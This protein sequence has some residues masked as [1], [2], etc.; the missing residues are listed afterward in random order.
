MKSLWLQLKLQAQVQVANLSRKHEKMKYLMS[1]CRYV[2]I[3]LW[4][5]AIFLG[6]GCALGGV[7]VPW[8]RVEESCTPRTDGDTDTLDPHLLW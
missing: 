4:V 3:R 5:V 6:R 7:G 1:E 2:A 8:L